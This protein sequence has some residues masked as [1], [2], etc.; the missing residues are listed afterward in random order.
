M[1]TEGY[2]LQDLRVGCP[3][4]TYDDGT[5][6]QMW[7]HPNSDVANAGFPSEEVQRWIATQRESLRAA[8]VACV[9]TGWARRSMIEDYGLSPVRVAVVGMG[10]KPRHGASEGRNWSTPTYL[11]V[12]IDWRRK[13]GERVLEAFRTV[14]DEIPEARLHLVGIHDPVEAPGV[15]DHGLL[16][17]NDPAAQ[18]L[19]DHLFAESTVFLLPSLFD[20]SPIAYLEAASAG[21]PVIATSQGGAGELLG[22]AAIVV[23][24]EDA[25]ALVDA[26]LRLADAGR[27]QRLGAA[28][29]SA[30][31]DSS[32]AAVAGRILSAAG[33]SAGTS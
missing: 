15:I 33:V 19:L 31:G 26:M 13:N 20:P 32:W 5:F 3:V 10:H 28:A 2:R 25:G 7:R 1:I 11:F 24:P 22:E 29:A 14:H 23:D 27:A 16:R 17:K 30:A 12:G 21:L 4:A 6:Q 18:E 9:S 8:D